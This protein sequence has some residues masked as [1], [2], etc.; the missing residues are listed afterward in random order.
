MIATAHMLAGSA[1]A[2]HLVQTER[3]KTQLILKAVVYALVSHVVLDFIPHIEPSSFGT[4]YTDTWSSGWWMA[5]VDNCAGIL[6]LFYWM[7]RIPEL[8]PWVQP[9]CAFTIFLAWIP[10]FLWYLVMKDVWTGSV[11][12]NYWLFHEALHILRDWGGIPLGIFTTLLIILG[13]WFALYGAELKYN[14]KQLYAKFH[15]AT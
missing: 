4:N 14:H 3:R 5:V 9:L 7:P 2:V 6:T 11:A 8:K 15:T 13:A 1:I 10:D 12:Q